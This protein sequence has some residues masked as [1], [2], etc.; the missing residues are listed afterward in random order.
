MNDL[1]D[2]ERAVGGLLSQLEAPARRKLARQVATQLHRSQVGRIAQQR[3][4]DG[5]PY[6]PRRPQ[7]REKQGRI[8]RTIFARLRTATYL[9]AAADADS[10]AVEFAG[11]VLRVARVHQFGL[12]DRVRRN[13]P[14]VRYPARQLLGFTDADERL[15]L[16][17]V[18][19]HLAP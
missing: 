7:L 16:D 6:A 4:P 10:A 9:K 19:A 8:R 13:G 18:M 5:T 2:L 3:N 12:D 15:V 14:V 1:L 17:L 11:R